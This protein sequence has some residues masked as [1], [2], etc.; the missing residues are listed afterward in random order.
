MPLVAQ[1][2]CV[3]G[4]VVLHDAA[5]RRNGTNIPVSVSFMICPHACF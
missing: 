3:R 4:V 1:R 5:V 2:K